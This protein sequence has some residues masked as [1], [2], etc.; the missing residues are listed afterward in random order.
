MSLRTILKQTSQ[1]DILIA[2]KEAELVNVLWL[3][4]RSAFIEILPPFSVDCYNFQMAQLA[5]VFYVAVTDFD[6]SHVQMKKSEIDYYVMNY[7][8]ED[9]REIFSNQKPEPNLFL[10][11]SAV[12]N[13]INYVKRNIN[14][15]IIGDIWSPILYFSICYINSLYNVG[16][17][18][19]LFLHN[20][21][22]I[23]GIDYIHQFQIDIK[24]E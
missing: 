21:P 4:P 12:R 19:F 24:E 7:L 6:Y 11:I 1:C 10:Y 16:V 14:E 3:K 9:N 17:S 2:S 23:F 8:L 20:Y 18:L 13:C 5:R 15:Y 22:S